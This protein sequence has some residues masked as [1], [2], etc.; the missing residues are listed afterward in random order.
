MQHESLQV[1]LTR[2]RAPVIK[3]CQ[4]IASGAL[5][6][7]GR[8]WLSGG[9]SSASSMDGHGDGSAGCAFNIAANRHST[10]RAVHPGTLA[11]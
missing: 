2:R 5:G 1:T 10:E 6:S 3:P 7:V 8:R 11:V 4:K 9:R